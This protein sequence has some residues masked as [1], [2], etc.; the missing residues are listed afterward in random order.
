MVRKALRIFFLNLINF[1][2]DEVIVHPEYKQVGL[3]N[4]ICILKFNKNGAVNLK[5]HNGAP[6]C[7]PKPGTQPAH[8]TRCWSAGWGL[9]DHPAG[10]KSL[11]QE[12][13]EVDLQETCSI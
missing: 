1:I 3:V 9:V 6:A 11:P 8:G 10:F 5:L 7:L 4:D 2:A 13:Q 12:L